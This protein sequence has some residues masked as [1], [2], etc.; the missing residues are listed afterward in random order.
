MME[1]LGMQP[2]P[3]ANSEIFTALQM[4]TV[5]GQENPQN[6]YIN[7]KYFEVNRYFSMTRHVFSVEPV[8]M[9][10]DLWNMLT[11]DEQATLMKAF[12]DATVYQR[13]LA[14]E[15]EEN[16]LKQVLAD[17]ADIVVTYIDDLTP[18]QEAVAGV[19]DKYKQTDLKPYIE[20]LEAAKAKVG[21]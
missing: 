6:N 8:G 16:Q 19:Y 18:F 21:E 13:Q 4:G 1:A 11:E 10:L 3:L 17:G 9:N 14:Q 2:V 5:D 12:D 20:A 7:N 15:T